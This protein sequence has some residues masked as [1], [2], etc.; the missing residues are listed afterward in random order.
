MSP[1][2]AGATPIVLDTNAWLD[3][4]VF[5]DPRIGAIRTA[6]GEDRLAAFT[7]ADCREEWRRVLDYPV[8]ALDPA[9]Q[10]AL[11]REFDTLTRPY[12]GHAID[13][14]PLP[15][16]RDADDQKFLELARACGAR[17]L[18][19]RDKALLRLN[20]KTVRDHG[21]SVLVPEAW[22]PGEAVPPG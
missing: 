6:L 8:L 9:R 15:R 10:A 18:V 21:F 1:T 16:C 19:S 11:L 20:R 3:L 13:A 14:P 12:D 17:W 7:D 5:E 22:R 2:A 4:L